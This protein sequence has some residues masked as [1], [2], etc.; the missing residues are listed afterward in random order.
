MSLD[1]RSFLQCVLALMASATAPSL[2]SPAPATRPDKTEGAANEG[3]GQ[4]LGP[5]ETRAGDLLA[6][7]SDPSAASRLGQQYLA[8]HPQE[9][10]ANRLADQLLL[11]LRAQQSN[12][13]TSHPIAL[14]Q[15]LIA[16][17]QREY[18]SA[19]LIA[20]DG[21]LLAP[22]EARLY[23]LAAL[24]LAQGR[25]QGQAQGQARADVA[26]SRERCDLRC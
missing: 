11:A 3:L 10:D 9:R 15:A 7:L 26:T 1:R 24:V 2:A 21:W 6:V 20:V 12:R 4:G 17:V 19:P 14:Q 13:A 25:A 22:S 23:A 8:E 16:L 18:V 5:R